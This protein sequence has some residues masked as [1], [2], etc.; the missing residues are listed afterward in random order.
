MD[1]LASTGGPEGDDAANPWRDEIVR[2]I[3]GDVGLI[4]KVGSVWAVQLR[5]ARA[6]AD[7]TARRLRGG[8]REAAPV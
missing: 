4:R 8:D 2:T 1:P 6:R 7:R 3:F 5:R